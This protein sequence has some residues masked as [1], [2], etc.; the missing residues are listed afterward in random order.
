MQL[1]IKEKLVGVV[2]ILTASYI[3]ADFFS[4]ALHNS[5]H[6]WTGWRT[7]TGGSPNSI[8]SKLL[9]VSK[10]TIFLATFFS[11]WQLD[12]LINS[13]RRKKKPTLPPNQESLR[14]KEKEAKPTQPNTETPKGVN[15][16]KSDTQEKET[17]SPPIPEPIIFS[18]DIRHAEV[19]GLS[20]EESRNFSIVKSTYRRVIAQYHPDKV[21]AMGPEIREIA[22]SKA[23]EINHAYQYFRKKFKA[24]RSSDQ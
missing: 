2:A 15:P 16:E 22:E 1:S 13:G 6:D 14:K 10:A 20:F 19:L 3:S 5:Y 4:V 18:E 24:D 8:T 21:G 23:K 7:I 9:P 12:R 17:K 11:L